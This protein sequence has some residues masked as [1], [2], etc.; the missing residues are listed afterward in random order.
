[1]E[2]LVWQMTRVRREWRLP[3]LCCRTGKQ[4]PHTLFH[5]DRDSVTFKHACP[6]L[7]HE[8]TSNTEVINSVAPPPHHPLQPLSH[9]QWCLFAVPRGEKC[10]ALPVFVL[11]EQTG[12]GLMSAQ[13]SSRLARAPAQ[14]GKGSAEGGVKRVLRLPGGDFHSLLYR[15]LCPPC[16]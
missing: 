6:I 7:K 15:L 1:M 8:W 16:N 4:P 10:N 11:W 12:L 5:G 3:Q 13:K 2:L 14:P 9:P